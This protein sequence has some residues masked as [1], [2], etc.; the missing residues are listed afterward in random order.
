MFSFP[1]MRRMDKTP[2]REEPIRRKLLR[3]PLGRV[4]AMDLVSYKDAFACF[5]AQGAIRE[6]EDQ[7]EQTPYKT[8][9]W[10]PWS[11]KVAVDGEELPLGIEYDIIIFPYTAMSQQDC[12]EILHRYSERYIRGTGNL[13]GYGRVLCVLPPVNVTV[14]W[15][16]TTMTVLAK[17]SIHIHRDMSTT[18]FESLKPPDWNWLTA[19]VEE[20]THPDG[21]VHRTHLNPNPKGAPPVHAWENHVDRYEPFNIDYCEEAAAWLRPI[22]D[23]LIRRHWRRILGAQGDRRLFILTPRDQELETEERAL[24]A[25]SAAGQISSDSSLL[26]QHRIIYEYIQRNVWLRAGPEALGFASDMSTFAVPIVA[27]EFLEKGKVCTVC[28][29]DVFDDDHRA[30]RLRVCGHVFGEPCLESLIEHD[31]GKSKYLCP[32]C[33][34]MICNK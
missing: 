11:A 18:A 31:K 3:K 13:H 17:D 25:S 22:S 30:T 21:R 8:N 24:R 15:G 27:T 6:P 16:H 34:K 10:I 7:V 23:P 9:L 20:E 28:M 32:N 29:S 5:G 33:R 19:H 12:L 1:Q 26:Y 4:T 14:T 2:L